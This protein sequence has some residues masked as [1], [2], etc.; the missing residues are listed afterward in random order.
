MVTIVDSSDVP[1]SNPAWY[2]EVVGD[3]NFQIKSDTTTRLFISSGGDVGIGTT[4][5]T[6]KLHVKGDSVLSENATGTVGLYQDVTGNVGIGTT[7]PTRPLTVRGTETN[8]ELIS[9]ENSTGSLKWH[10]NLLGGGLNFVE[11]GVADYRLFLKAGGNIGIGTSTPGSKLTVAGI[12][13]STTGGFK[14]PDG[15]VQLTASAGELPYGTPTYFT[16]GG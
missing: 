3:E 16:C 8:H 14:F 12:I 10:L 7:S 1:A 6:S 11:S 2:I 15:T 9:L 13:E 5:P 4:T